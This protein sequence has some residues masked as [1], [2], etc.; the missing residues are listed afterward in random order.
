MRKPSIVYKY[1]NNLYINITN[2]CPVRCS[3]CIKF[4]WK[5]LFRGYYLG[6]TKEPSFKEI[7]DALEKEIKTHP[8]IKEIVFCGYGEPLMRWRLVK[9]LA[10]WIKTN[11]PKKFKIRV[12][13]DGLA[14]ALYKINICRYLKDVIDSIS[15]SLNA[16]NEDV[17]LKLH[18]TKIKKPFE[19]IIKFIIQA[20]KYIKE[21]VVT[22]IEHPM[23]D[24]DKVRCI[25]K[26]LAVKFVLRPYLINYEKK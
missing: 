9:K 8:N 4:R 11:Y 16:H 20:K 5:K 10:L 22:T 7:R 18:K 2:R 3:Y 14:N 17:Y 25:A 13:T 21:V 12:N 15:V 26:K 24:V 6:L 19:Q 23:I 1:K